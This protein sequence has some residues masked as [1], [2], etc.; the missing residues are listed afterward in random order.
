MA[1]Y[2]L[3]IETEDADELAA[4]AVRLAATL[5]AATLAETLTAATLPDRVLT[6]DAAAAPDMQSRRRGRPPKTLDAAPAAEP[7]PA[8]VAEPPSAA[9]VVAPVAEPPAPEPPAGEVTAGDL[10]DYMTR[11]FQG[12]RASAAKIQAIFEATVGAKSVTR[13][14]GPEDYAKALAALKATDWSA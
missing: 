11:L 1:K 9:Q 3:S 7:P 10:K 14:S 4:I 13:M 2:T 5:T 6:A 8:P 12:G